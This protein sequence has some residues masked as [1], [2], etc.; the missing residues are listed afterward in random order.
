MG[1]I[2]GTP[3]GF[4][5]LSRTV[6]EPW[7]SSRRLLKAAFKPTEKREP[8]T[9]QRQPFVSAGLGNALRVSLTVPLKTHLFLFIL[10]PSSRAPH[11]QPPFWDEARGTGSLQGGQ[12][13]FRCTQM[14][15]LASDLGATPNVFS[16][17]WKRSPVLSL[18]TAQSGTLH[19]RSCCQP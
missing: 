6:R 14:S 8:F 4:V 7:R 11:S 13:L 10:P 17:S 12:G 19:A 3:C 18:L 2:N 5:R 9:Q 16:I 1:H 15:D